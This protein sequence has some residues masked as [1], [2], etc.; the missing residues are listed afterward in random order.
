MVSGLN[1]C[2]NHQYLLSLMRKTK[3]YGFLKKSFVKTTQVVP[4]VSNVL[5][6][7]LQDSSLH[8]TSHNSF[9]VLL[10]KTHVLQ[11][12]HKQSDMTIKSCTFVNCSCLGTFIGNKSVSGFLLQ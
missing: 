8:L 5:W 12:L 4:N 9:I 7:T 11:A 2:L 3:V 10:A 1:Q 6:L